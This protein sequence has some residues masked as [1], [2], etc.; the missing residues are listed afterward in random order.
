MTVT[1]LKKI[2]GVRPSIDST[3]VLITPEIATKI[4]NENN[5]NNRQ[6]SKSRV[7]LWKRTMEQG[8]FKVSNDMITFGSDGVLT[9]GQHRLSAVRDCGIAEYFYVGFGIDNFMGMDTG[10]TRSVVDNAQIFDE[11]DE[12]LRTSNMAIVHKI[13][14]SAW[15]FNTGCYKCE[16]RIQS[17]YLNC[18]NKYANELVRLKGEGVFSSIS[19]T[20]ADGKRRTL[21]SVSVFSAYFLAYLNG[22]DIEVLK[23]IHHI[24]RTGEKTSEFDK[25]I[26]A[27]RDLLLTTYGGGRVPDTNR[28]TATQDCISKVVAKSRSKKLV[29]GKYY[30][31]KKDL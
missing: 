23:H 27:L 29:I 25:P 16:S 15:C 3:K 22:V 30:Y 4:L 13:V 5:T 14:K 26:L 12:R 7:D 19:V 2:L 28:H 8:E 20:L 24:L 10:K 17:E 21:T 31:I 11:C 18:A 1:Q 9:N 6:I